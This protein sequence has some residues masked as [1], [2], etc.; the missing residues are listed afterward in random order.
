MPGQP[1]TA[2]PSGRSAAGGARPPQQEPLRDPGGVEAAGVEHL[3]QLGGGREVPVGQ[4]PQAVQQDEDVA[5]G[6]PGRSSRFASGATRA[7]C[8]AR[9]P[10]PRELLPVSTQNPMHLP[11]QG[12]R[13]SLPQA[14]R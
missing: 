10:K 8:S 7:T 9:I 14:M 5:R 12:S 11:T 3:I 6:R 13:L 4:F 2:H 1:G